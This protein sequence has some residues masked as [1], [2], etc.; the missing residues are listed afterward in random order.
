MFLKAGQWQIL[1]TWW[2]AAWIIIQSTQFKIKIK[3]NSHFHVYSHYCH[4]VQSWLPNKPSS[5]TSWRKQ[6]DGNEDSA[7]GAYS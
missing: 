6:Q 2:V 7:A 5:G 3:L 4:T 1:V